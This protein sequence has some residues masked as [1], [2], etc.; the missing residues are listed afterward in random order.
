VKRNTDWLS[1]ATHP[2]NWKNKKNVKK[3]NFFEFF[4]ENQR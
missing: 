2:H 1:G 3:V 4:F